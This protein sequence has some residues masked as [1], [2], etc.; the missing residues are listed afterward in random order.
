MLRTFFLTLLMSVGVSFTSPAEAAV[1]S[2]DQAAAKNKGDAATRFASA[3][4]LIEKT[5]KEKQLASISVAVAKDGKIIWEEGFGWADRERRIPAT[6]HTPY[7]LASVNKPITATAIMM[8]NQAGKLDVNAPIENYLG[9]VRLQGHAGSTEGVTARRLMAHSAGLPGLSFFRLDGG[10]P[11]SSEQTISRY[12]IVTYEPG[13]RFEYSNIG[14]T[15][16][17]RAIE[18]VSGE[19]YGDYLRRNIFNPLGMTRTSLGQHSSW[20]SEAAVRYDTQG[21]AMRF[22]MTDHPASGDVWSS[23]HDMA[24][25]SMFHLG[26]L[27]STQKEILSREK[28]LEMQQPVS[29]LG[30]A[31]GAS[32]ASSKVGA[33]WFLSNVRGHR[34]VSHTG[35]QPGVAAYLDLYP[36]QKLAIVVLSNGEGLPSA[37]SKAIVASVAPE[38]VEAPPVRTEPVSQAPIPIAPGKWVGTV[39]TYEGVKPLALDFQ[40]DGDIH[41]DVDGR[42]SSLNSSRF[43]DGALTGSFYGSL[44]FG[45]IA[46]Y[47]HTLTFKLVPSGNELLGRLTVNTSNPDLVASLPSFVRLRLEGAPKQ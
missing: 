44:P 29:A 47:P 22:Y 21:R 4:A 2:A 46:K 37:I 32:M 40:A 10:E 33:N 23:A 16:L 30:Q 9:N 18:Q 25:F 31:L 34:R 45:D 24:L 13:T 7:S 39:T 19:S 27:L 5:L 35:G 36:D 14:L 15:V 12:G 8:L 41:V 38:L 20:A 17:G 42:R 28:V 6:A 1:K 26:T 3:R 43:V 11:A